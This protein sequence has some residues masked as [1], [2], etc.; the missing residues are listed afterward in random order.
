MSNLRWAEVVA[1]CA[2]SEL[3][4]CRMCAHSDHLEIAKRELRA[5]ATIELLKLKG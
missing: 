4:T 3:R 2:I 1:T 5:K